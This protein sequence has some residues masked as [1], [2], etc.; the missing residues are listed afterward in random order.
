[1]H[2]WHKLYKH[3]KWL[4]KRKIILKRDNY[5]CTACGS[6][7]NLCVHHTFYY[8]TYTPP[9]DYPND[10]L[11]TV[12]EECH[13]EWHKYHEIEYRKNSNPKRCRSRKTNKS[14]K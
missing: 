13:E 3:S 10:S 14:I 12:C 8:S 9:W 5:K 1:M 7:K 6:K 11:L 2:N 4:R